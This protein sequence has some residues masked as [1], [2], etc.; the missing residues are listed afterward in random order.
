VPGFVVRLAINV[1][2]LWFASEIV[3]GMA[4]NGFGSFVLA[5]ILLGVV[6]ALARPIA[7]LLTLPFTVVT[8][9]LFLLV[10]NAGML[11]LVAWFL[12]AFTLSGFWAAF[13]GSIVVSLA[14]GFASQFIGPRGNI[15]VMV[16]ESHSGR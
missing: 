11:G 3:P 10:V 13:F 2:G 14:S 12:D 1:F 8:L 9:G 5:G 7:I 6:N 4:I 15:E 16:I